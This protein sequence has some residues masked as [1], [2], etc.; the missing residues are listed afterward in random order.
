M[1]GAAN[2]RGHPQGDVGCLRKVS[3]RPFIVQNWIVTKSTSDQ[4]LLRQT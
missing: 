1:V 4:S 2:H 3:R